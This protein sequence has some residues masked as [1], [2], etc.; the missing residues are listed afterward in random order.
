MTREQVDGMLRE[1]RALIGRCGHIDA[2]IGRLGRA[3]EAQRASFERDACAPPVSRLTGMPR[4]GA[5]G[6]PTA[7][8]A[9]MLMDGRAFEDSPQRQEIDRL[10]GEIARL[11]A[12]REEKQLRVRFVD[13]WLS[14]LPER[15]RW[16]IERHVIEGEIWHDIIQQ[17]NL[18][19]MDDVSK[20][21]LKR[22]QQKALGRIYAM[23]V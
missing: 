11:R 15:E 17:F 22:M 10:E 7:R 21:R 2:E 14:G 6:D 20:D 8:T 16:V 5:P 1:Y 19:Y 23:A 4:G 18:R 12:E 3:I 13:S 9:L